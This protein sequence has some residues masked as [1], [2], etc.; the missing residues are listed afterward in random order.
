MVFTNSDNESDCFAV[1][2]NTLQLLDTLKKVEVPSQLTRGRKKRNSPTLPTGKMAIGTMFHEIITRMKGMEDR[3]IGMGTAMEKWMEK[4]DKL[5][6]DNR[7]LKKEVNVC[8]KEIE[9][10][11]DWIEDL[12]QKERGKEIIISD[13]SITVSSEGFQEKVKAIMQNKLKLYH[14]TLDKLKVRKIGPADKPKALII[15][16][17]LEEKIEIFRVAKEKRPNNFYVNESLIPCRRNLFFECRKIKKEM[18]LTVS[19]YTYD[20]EIF[21]KKF[22]ERKSIKGRDIESF[23]STF[24]A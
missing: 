8:N 11:R 7:M 9:V 13:P 22:G 23:R 6:T 3:M 21:C 18:N 2:D 24:N 12:E 19:V 10:L 17:N 4:I 1:D 5:E 15:M 20:G 16:E 14:K